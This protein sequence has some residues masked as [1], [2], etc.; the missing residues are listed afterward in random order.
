V[1]IESRRILCAINLSRC[2]NRMLHEPGFV[3]IAW[4][5]RADAVD[6]SRGARARA[7]TTRLPIG[8]FRRRG[9]RRCRA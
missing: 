1:N 8:S 5:L 7:Y 4:T 3:K 2:S 9:G 6:A